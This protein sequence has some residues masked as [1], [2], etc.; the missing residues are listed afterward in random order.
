MDT[1]A[2]W[3]FDG[4]TCPFRSLVE[5]ECLSNL[6]RNRARYTDPVCEHSETYG[7]RIRLAYPDERPPLHSRIRDSNSNPI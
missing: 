5:F 2:F 7:V 3:D 4:D 1:V 6:K